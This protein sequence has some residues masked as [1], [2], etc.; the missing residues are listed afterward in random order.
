MTL[1]PGTVSTILWHFTGGPRWDALTKRQEPIPKPQDDAYRALLSILS[2]KEL[3]L[4]SYS[5]VFNVT[6]PLLRKRNRVTRKVEELENVEEQLTSSPVCCLADIP[7]VHL[8]YHAQRYGKFALG[9]RRDA[10]IR[11]R[12][13][14]V[15]YT[16]HSSVVANIIREGIRATE[17]IDPWYIESIVSDIESEVSSIQCEQGHDVELDIDNELSSIGEEVDRVVEHTDNARDALAQFLAFVKTFGDND[18]S[19]IYCERE[20]RSTSSFGF[21]ISDIAMI[22]LPAKGEH[23]RDFFSD[24][25]REE[26]GRLGIPREVPIVAWEDLLE[27]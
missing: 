24:L 26:I 17:R 16:L 4:G 9:F 3:R 5:E 11:Q 20:W 23:G 19:T 2:S 14:P 13:N 7:I 10:A 6:V 8:P 12:F 22:V 18:F 25:V 15:L 1:T 21:E 27:H